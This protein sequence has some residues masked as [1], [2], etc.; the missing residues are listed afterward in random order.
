MSPNIRCAGRWSGDRSLETGYWHPPCGWTGS[1]RHDP[2]DH[3]SFGPHGQPRSLT[4]NP[5]PECGGEVDLIV[6][7]QGSGG[8]R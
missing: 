1:R 4:R 6:S 7:D 3:S 5:C 8:A 2:H